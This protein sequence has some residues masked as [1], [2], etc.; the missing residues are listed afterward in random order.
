MWKAGHMLSCGK[1]LVSSAVLL[2]KVSESSVI[3]DTQG[4]T[5]DHS[6]VWMRVTPMPTRKNTRR[7]CV[8]V[9]SLTHRSVQSDSHPHSAAC[10]AALHA[11]QQE[12]RALLALAFSTTLHWWPLGI[13]PELSLVPSTFWKQQEKTRKPKWIRGTRNIPNNW[14][15][16]LIQTTHQHTG[17]LLI[18][19]ILRHV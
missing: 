15:D 18:C 6:L 8:N 16:T 3:G 14:H 19:R 13:L 2:F 17:I 9:D 10:Y 12:A 11:S 1:L 7:L 4:F 5:H